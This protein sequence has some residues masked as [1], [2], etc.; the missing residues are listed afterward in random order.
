MA[1]PVRVLRGVEPTAE[2]AMLPSTMEYFSVSAVMVPPMASNDWMAV[3]V[4]AKTV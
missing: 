4:G 2:E 1:C 3:S